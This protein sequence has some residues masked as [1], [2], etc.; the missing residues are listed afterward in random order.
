MGYRPSPVERKTTIVWDWSPEEFARVARMCLFAGGAFLM[1]TMWIAATILFVASTTF[2]LVSVKR[3]NAAKALEASPKYKTVDDP[4]YGIYQGYP[5]PVWNDNRI[6]RELGGTD[7][8]RCSNEECPSCYEHGICAVAECTDA[9]TYEWAF[10][11]FREP[12]YEWLCAEHFD[13][14][15]GEREFRKTVI[16]EIKQ[17]EEDSQ[18]RMVDGVRC[19]RP[20]TVP[21]YAAVR[22]SKRRPDDV[23]WDVRWTWVDTDTGE[24]MAARS[25]EL[26]LDSHSFDAIYVGPDEPKQEMELGGRPTWIQTGDYDEPRRRSP[27]KLQVTKEHKDYINREMKRRRFNKGYG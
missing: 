5:C 2:A 25:I 27:I 1:L 17:V 8:A 9:A 22:V 20:D 19:H 12:L 7:F 14:R 3:A 10:G 21:E 26:D 4:E 16:K 24:R 11:H 15:R 13:I 6:E 18:W 23:Q